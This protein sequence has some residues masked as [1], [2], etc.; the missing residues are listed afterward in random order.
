MLRLQ[1]PLVPQKGQSSSKEERLWLNP[2]CLHM[3]MGTVARCGQKHPEA[4]TTLLEYLALCLQDGKAIL[5]E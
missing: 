4:G 1:T 3:W 2:E 5:K